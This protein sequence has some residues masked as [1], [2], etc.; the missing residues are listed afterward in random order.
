MIL[1][2]EEVAYASKMEHITLDVRQLDLTFEWTR[3]FTAELRKS[4]IYHVSTIIGQKN[5]MTLVGLE[6]KRKCAHESYDMVAKSPQN[7]R[8][9][10]GG[11]HNAGQL[12][13][14]Q[15]LVF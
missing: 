8:D 6:W 10:K 7:V 4:S 13:H 12:V 3:H 1:I 5:H 15:F 2:K 9:T 11:E 14:Q